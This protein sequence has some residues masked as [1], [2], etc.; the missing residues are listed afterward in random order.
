[1]AGVIS[2]PHD[3]EMCTKLVHEATSLLSDEIECVE[4]FLKSTIPN[5]WLFFRL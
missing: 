3:E 2:Q 1:M 5:V 4:D